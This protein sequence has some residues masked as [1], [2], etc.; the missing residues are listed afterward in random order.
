MPEYPNGEQAMTQ[1]IVGKWGKNLAVRVPV[2]V[3]EKSG[4]SEGERVEIETRDGDIVIRRLKVS[5]AARKRA[6]RAVENIIANSK[7]V[8]LGGLTIKELI[9]E[10]RKR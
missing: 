1:A 5:D 7:G 8:T 10:G 3:A 9:N 4:L 2:E 6:L